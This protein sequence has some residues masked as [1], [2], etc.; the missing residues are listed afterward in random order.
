LRPIDFNARKS[1]EQKIIGIRTDFRRA[2]ES[3]GAVVNV[4]I[5]SS[6]GSKRVSIIRVDIVFVKMLK[7]IDVAVQGS[8]G[9]PTPLSRF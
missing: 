1:P 4:M 7:S 3:G 2:G 6:I 9:S 8:H 5:E